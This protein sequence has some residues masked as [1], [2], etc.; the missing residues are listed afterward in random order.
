MLSAVRQLAKGTELIAHRVT[1][2][3]DELRTLRQA[4]QALAKRQRAKRTRIQ[5]GGVLTIEDAQVLIAAK[6]TGNQQSRARLS[7]GRGSEAGLV[8]QRRCGKCGKTGH[9]VRTC[10]EVEE[11]LEEDTSTERN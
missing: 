6:E 9:N 3:E 5:A 4:N 1:L 8:I 2:L 10:Q 7:R 11:I